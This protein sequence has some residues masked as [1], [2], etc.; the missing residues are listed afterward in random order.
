LIFLCSQ[1]CTCGNGLKYEKGRESFCGWGC[2]GNT[3]KYVE[4]CGGGNYVSVYG[5][6][7]LFS[8]HL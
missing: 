6:G 3:Y 8:K 5:T 7:N 4:N 2:S 1:R